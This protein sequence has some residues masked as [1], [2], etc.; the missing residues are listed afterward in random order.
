MSRT[1]DHYR[2]S[3]GR[4]SQDFPRQCVFGGTTNA[5]VYL[6][7]ET[8]NRRFWPVKVGTIDLE[9]LRRDRGQLWAEAVVAYR[10]GERW[11]LSAEAKAL[12]T[13]QQAERR[14]VNPWEAEVIRL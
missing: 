7:D 13:E 8:G 2:P 5:D 11:W 10:N 1:G 12:A 14:I 4:L 6:L 3:Y 9:A